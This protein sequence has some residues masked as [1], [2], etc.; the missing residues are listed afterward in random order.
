MTPQRPREHHRRIAARLRAAGVESAEAE[1]WTLLS[2]ATGSSRSELVVDATPLAAPAVERLE[3]WVARREAREP[4]QHVL[5]TAPFGELELAVGPGV[6]VPRPETEV[7]VEQV[8]ARLE[9]VGVRRPR[10]LDVG[11]GSGAIALAIK[12]ARPD[13]EV[14]ATEVSPGAAAWARRNARGLGIAV[15]VIESDLLDEPVVA[16]FAGTVDALVANPPYL[17]EGDADALAPEVHADPPEALFGGPEGLGVARRL[18]AQAR[19]RLPRGALLALE[20]DPRNA[21]TMRAELQAAGWQATELAA[22]LAGRTRFV[23]ARAPG[24]PGAAGAHP[25]AASTEARR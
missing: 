15:P 9:T 17:P 18:T 1:A 23:F 3:R 6:L 10:V 24:A 20:L 22:D 8:L 11:T 25:R 12:R 5:G 2:A 13:A 21:A 4:L 16:A 19:S 14:L 7:L